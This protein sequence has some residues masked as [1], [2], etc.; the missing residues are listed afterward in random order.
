MWQLASQSS[1]SPG[2]VWALMPIWFDMVPDGTNKAAS[3]PRTAATRSSSRRAVGSSL[4]TSSPTSAAAMAARMA[5]VGRV[6]V[7]LRKSMMSGMELPQLRAL[8]L[9][10]GL[11]VRLLQEPAAVGLHERDGAVAPLLEA[12][13]GGRAFLLPSALFEEGPQLLGGAG[14]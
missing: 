3:L 4:K 6:T 13:R 2:W 12:D 8:A 9:R 14:V 11:P 7:S 10:R 1:S 5:G